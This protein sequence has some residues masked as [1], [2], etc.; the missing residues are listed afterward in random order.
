MGMR[1]VM[2][3]VVVM[4][5]ESILAAPYVWG[6]DE[7]AEAAQVGVGDVAQRQLLR[8]TD[9][10]RPLDPPVVAERLIRPLGRLSPAEVH[11]QMERIFE[12]ERTPDQPARKVF[13]RHAH[14]ADAALQ[15]EVAT[16]N[17]APPE[18]TSAAPAHDTPA[19]P[20]SL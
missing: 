1:W 11:E 12:R 2:S 20:S 9:P 3:G 7:T 5:L 10:V 14:G 18:P 4:A 17:S 6:A 13:K 16:G 8:T 19:V 15:S